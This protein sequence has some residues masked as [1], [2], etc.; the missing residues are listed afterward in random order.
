MLLKPDPKYFYKHQIR[1]I[2]VLFKFFSLNLN[3]S[4]RML[5]SPQ[6]APAFKGSCLTAD[7]ILITVWRNDQEIYRGSMLGQLQSGEGQPTCPGVRLSLP[8]LLPLSHWDPAARF[9]E[10]ESFLTGAKGK[11]YLA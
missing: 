11:V 7:W 1:Q 2:L 8:P 4:L 6:R 10:G 9:E 5:F 3:F